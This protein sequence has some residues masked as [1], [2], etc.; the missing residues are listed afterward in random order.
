MRLPK[1]HLSIYVTDASME[2]KLITGRSWSD[3]LDDAMKDNIDDMFIYENEYKILKK[4][5]STCHIELELLNELNMRVSKLR[6]SRNKYITLLI[7]A[8]VLKEGGVNERNR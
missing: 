4:H 6:M 7:H 5:G 1:A 3:I 8:Y 2:Y